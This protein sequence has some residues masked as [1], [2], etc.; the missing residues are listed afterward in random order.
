MMTD[1]T[2]VYRLVS[3]VLVF[4]LLLPGLAVLYAEKEVYWPGE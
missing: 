3:I 1:E 4:G 2:I